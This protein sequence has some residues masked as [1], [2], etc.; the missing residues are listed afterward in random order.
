MPWAVGEVGGA[1]R[2][3]KLTRVREATMGGQVLGQGWS[4]CPT[5]E[6]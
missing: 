4:T 3:C 1:G 2:K 6:A 5:G